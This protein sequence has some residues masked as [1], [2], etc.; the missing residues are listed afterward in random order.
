MSLI[1]SICSLRLRR[2]IPPVKSF[3]K[4][5][6]CALCHTPN[7]MKSTPGGG[8]TGELNS[9]SMSCCYCGVA[10]SNYCDYLPWCESSKL[11]THK[12]HLR[13]VIVSHCAR[14]LDFWKIRTNQTGLDQFLEQGRIVCIIGDP[15]TSEPCQTPWNDAQ[16]KWQTSTKRQ[17][18]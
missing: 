14:R 18:L 10:C 8:V 4:V 5:G 16:P 11:S 15:S 3:S 1:I 6:R 7:F 13:S 9:H 12:K 17:A 2:T